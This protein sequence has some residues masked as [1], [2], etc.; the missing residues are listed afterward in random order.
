MIMDRYF[1]EKPEPLGRVIPKEQEVFIKLMIEDRDFL[2]RVA[3]LIDQN[4][5]DPVE[6]RDVVRTI[7]DMYAE[8]CEIT[9]DSVYSRVSSHYDVTELSKEISVLIIKCAL[10]ECKTG[11]CIE[12]IP[13]DKYKDVFIKRLV[14][15]RYEI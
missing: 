3:D 1:I 2:F 9:Y 4:W 13:I 8:G 15:R 7:K 10:D 12:R 11:E 6:L 14:E 5:F